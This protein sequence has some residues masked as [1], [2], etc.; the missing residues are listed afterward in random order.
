M[1]RGHI[2]FPTGRSLGV[3]LFCLLLPTSA[4]ASITL[5][6]AN[7][8]A[9]SS[10]L[11][12]YWPLDGATTNWKTGIT[13]DMS[14]Q[15]NNGALTS[16]ST[17]TSPVAGKVGQALTFSSSGRI[18]V[19][20]S[21]SIDLNDV[22]TVVFWMKGL[23]STT[24]YLSF[25]GKRTGAPLGWIIQQN[26]LSSQ[27]YMRID[28]SGGT[29]QT[30]GFI[31][32]ALD[33]TWHQ[34]VYVFNTGARAAYKDGV[35]VQAS[36]YIPGTGVS[37]SGSFQLNGLVGSPISMD[38]VRMYNRALSATEVALL[39]AGGKANVGVVATNALSS[40]LVGHWTMDGKD[41]GTSVV[42]S[43]GNG[44]NGYLVGT[45]N[46][47]S[48]RKS[49]GKVGQAFSF[50]GQTTGG[51]NLG[52]S[53]SLNP[54]RFTISGWINVNNPQT[55]AYN[56][57]Y[58]NARDNCQTGLSG[59]DFKIYANDALSG[60]ICGAGT[61]HSVSYG[62]AIAT[63]TWTHVA[64]SYDGSN[65]RLYKNGVLVATQA[66][67]TDPATP[68]FNS[69]IGS[70]AIS[71]GSSLTLNG[72]LDDVRLYN[73]ALSNTEIAQLAAQGGASVGS[74]N[75]VSQTGINSGLVGYWTFDGK[76]MNWK[77]GK[78]LDSSGNSNDGTLV[79]LGTTSSP[80][81]GKIG[82][83]LKFSGIGYIDAGTLS[84][85]NGATAFTLAV[86]VKPR[87][88]PFSGHQGIFGRGDSTGSNRTPW[89]WGSS[90]ASSLCMQFL[91]TLGG[92]ADGNLCTSNLTAG[93]WTHVIYTWDGSTVRNY[94]NGIQYGFDT[95]TGHILSDTDATTYLGYIYGYAKW[96]GLLDD[97]RVYNRALSAAEVLQ[98]YNAGK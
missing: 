39:Y 23:P 7:T 49:I 91:T 56:Y 9:L 86:W 92:A 64:F 4:F 94:V 20:N 84:S 26:N 32:N 18:T 80:A 93:T 36:T 52:S 95:T 90:G 25:M 29:N 73:R 41:I 11:V 37:N 62:N 88:L 55:Y 38:D 71:N 85:L 98:L 66:N 35:L 15:G 51:I 69:Y 70:M 79:S 8:S 96:D 19:P 65:L 1:S 27:I 82:Q 76:N 43:S 34:I 89:L 53:S 54:T 33:G 77:T 31:N 22:T 67:T 48:S 63:S 17:T 50:G 6:H 5:G 2:V 72:K 28:T 10:G 97:L 30:G 12:G 40:G 44:F 46:A 83:A 16:M 59:I 78:A 42:D 45:N 58:S 87:S 68:S 60:T 14:G 21:G 13:S 74:S 3:L 57:I 47:T 75:T 61:V 24:A 81:I